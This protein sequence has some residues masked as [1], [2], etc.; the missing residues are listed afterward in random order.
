[1]RTRLHA[2]LLGKDGELLGWCE[3]P[4]EARGDGKL[5]S[6]TPT[7][8][9][10]ECDGWTS[11]LSLHWVDV[12]VEVRQSIPEVRVTFGQPVT[13]LTAGPVFMVGPMPDALAPVTVRTP[14]MVAPPSG[15]IAALTR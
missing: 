7:V 11:F 13:I 10:A 12:N 3:V 6:A 8:L 1:M 14:A 2:R 4:V 5:W 15:G 9:V